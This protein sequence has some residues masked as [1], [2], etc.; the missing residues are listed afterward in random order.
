MGW[1]L[2]LG[3]AGLLLLVLSLVFDGVLE[4]IFDGLGAGPDGLLSLP[5]IA[6]FMSMLGFAGAI[7]LGTTGLGAVAAAATGV[8]AGTGAGWLTW[9]LSR[10]L[11]R[12][13]DASAAP[14]RDDLLG[15]SGPVVT[16][17]PAD[18]YGEV[19]LYP[20]GQPRKFA[21][22]SSSPVTRGTE[23]WVESVLSATS[24]TVRPVER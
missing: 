21:A 4:G 15:T 5:V 22:K 16:G 6:G 10:A 12:D 14:R 2:G 9:R 18:G 20:G 13:D 1:F 23:V 7:T 8:L 19:L 24:V 11:M 17:I 3:A